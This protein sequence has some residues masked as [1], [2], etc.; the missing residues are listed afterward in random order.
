VF[1]RNNPPDV[2]DEV[3]LN[4]GGSATWALIAASSGT[5]FV[6]LDTNQTITG[7]KTFTQDTLFT[8]TTLSLTASGPIE[9]TRG[10]GSTATYVPPIMNHSGAA[11]ASD[12]HLV[13]D[14]ININA[15]VTSTITLTGD[16][17][18]T[19][20]IEPIV[21]ADGSPTYPTTTAISSSSFSIKNNAAGVLTF[22]YIVAGD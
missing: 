21:T 5:G 4:V 19:T 3:Y 2:A 13:R 1:F 18:F 20:H 16:A 22:R 12:A 10:G 9:A 8:N 15:G 14:D 17:P 6:T 11:A 7:I